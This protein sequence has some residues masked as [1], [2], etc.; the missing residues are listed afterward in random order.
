MLPGR[1]KESERSTPR[2]EADPERVFIF[3]DSIYSSWHEDAWVDFRFWRTVWIRAVRRSRPP[4]STEPR[5]WCTRSI[6][7][8]RSSVRALAC[9]SECAPVDKR[10]VHLSAVLSVVCYYVE[11]GSWDMIYIKSVCLS[12]RLFTPIYHNRFVYIGD[13]RYLYRYVPLRK[14]NTWKGNSC[15][16]AK[17]TTKNT[18]YRPH[19]RKVPPPRGLRKFGFWRSVTTP[20]NTFPW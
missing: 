19:H 9:R 20:D 11:L 16:L 3:P 5:L 2:A 13:T 17:E 8:S 7:A 14:G 6:S 15:F 1:S 4:Q 12:T 18:F 10:L